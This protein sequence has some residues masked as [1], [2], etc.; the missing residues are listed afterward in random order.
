MYKNPLN[1][2]DI[3]DYNSL[4]KQRD[5]ATIVKKYS[6]KKL[7]TEPTEL[8]KYYQ[9]MTYQQPILDELN[10]VAERLKTEDIETQKNN[11]NFIEDQKIEREK[12]MKELAGMNKENIRNELFDA[13]S[14]KKQEDLTP[15]ITTDLELE[16]LKPVNEIDNLIGSLFDGYED[17]P[18][19]KEE[20]FELSR[21]EEKVS[22][23]KKKRE[24]RKKAKEEQRQ[25]KEEE[26]KEEESIIKIENAI[27]QKVK[28]DRAKKELEELKKQKEEL[29]SATDTTPIVEK[30]ERG[31][32]KK[33][34]QNPDMMSTTTNTTSIVEKKKRGRPK[35]KT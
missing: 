1:N 30:L 2:G 7:Q 6:S 14:M 20:F 19:I 4:K 12:K 25:K 22:K 26:K 31:R 32:P 3:S 5:P 21:T 9:Y 28:R 24:G 11:F 17:N 8:Q 33:Q 35:K 10:Y 27:L 16:Y 29:M 18:P 15:T 23:A 34:E 13:S